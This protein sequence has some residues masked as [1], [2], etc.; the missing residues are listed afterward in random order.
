MNLT[1]F[2]ISI[3][4][5]PVF[6]YSQ[7]FDYLDKTE[8]ERNNREKTNK[9]IKAPNSS[10]GGGAKARSTGASQTTCPAPSPTGANHTARGSAHNRNSQSRCG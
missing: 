10:R 1:V 4:Q 8:T 3:F 9:R 7:Y 5:D 2:S 6:H